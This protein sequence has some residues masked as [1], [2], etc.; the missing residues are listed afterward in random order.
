MAKIP[1][2]K[3]MLNVEAH[4]SYGMSSDDFL[5]LFRES[6]PN[7]TV[8]T[9]AFRPTTKEKWLES[10]SEATQFFGKNTPVLC[11]QN[12]DHLF[13]EYCPNEFVLA[14]NRAFKEQQSENN[15]MIFSHFPEICSFTASPLSYANRL[16][17]LNGL[18]FKVT[19]I[20]KSIDGDTRTIEGFLAS[21]FITTMRGL[22]R[23]WSNA[24]VTTDYAPR[25]EWA[26]VSYGKLRFNI[27][28]SNREFFRHYDGYGHVTMIPS[29]LGMSE[30]DIDVDLYVE[31]YKAPLAR[32]ID[33]Q[34]LS[35]TPPTQQELAEAYVCYFESN[36]LL[37]FRDFLFF[38]SRHRTGSP[39][40][41]LFF[42]QLV[43]SLCKANIER[44]S[45]YWRQG[46]YELE[47]VTLWTKH[48]LYSKINLY[49]SICTA[50][51]AYIPSLRRRQLR[52]LASKLL[53]KTF[54]WGRVR[55]IMKK[56]YN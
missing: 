37:A 35:A 54:L 22:R 1:F 16:S 32:S 49:I 14:V 13:V 41:M 51:C 8:V 15:Y 9:G 34:V 18:D 44:D 25:S 20:V 23:V 10:I 17:A 53:K 31:K 55:G 43:D 24:I 12:H 27:F 36:Y 39:D 28:Y 29:C 26:G 5:E 48:L 52:Q 3:V 42:G 7:A 2:T 46:S 33:S 45:N 38:S 47:K 30:D 4:E 6:F 56:S 19:K 21:F 11:V 40:L 50:D